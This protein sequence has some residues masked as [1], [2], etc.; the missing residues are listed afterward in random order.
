MN[1]CSQTYVVII[2][3]GS[4]LLGGLTNYFMLYDKSLTTREQWIKAIASVLLSL[5]ASLT[6]P[7]F[8]QILSNNL[9]DSL[10]F[11]N[12]LIF[13]GFCVI[14]SFFS[15]RFLEDVYSKLERLNKKIDNTREETKDKVESMTKKTDSVIKKVD[16]LEESIE[17]I[18]DGELPSGIKEA[19][20]ENK[21]ISFKDTEV[22]KIIESLFSE[23]FSLRTHDG[24]AKQTNLPADKIKEL[25]EHLVDRGLAEKKVSSQGKDLWRILKYPIKIYSASYGVQGKTV[26]VTNK[27]KDL[28]SQGTYE[29]PVSPGFLGVEDPAY[30]IGKVLKIHCRIYGKE[31]ELSFFDGHTFKIV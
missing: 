9:L 27:I 3:L 7:L 25:L 6:V 8:L 2:I 19:I 17:S 10:T 31:K 14:A 4:G 13:T 29:G 1:E 24:I 28:V 23:K 5:C 26:D 30:G 16:D 15:K 18:E 22:E 12:G 11:K 20:K 21:S